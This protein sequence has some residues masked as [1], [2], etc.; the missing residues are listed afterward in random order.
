MSFHERF[1]PHIATPAGYGALIDA[2]QL[3][4]PLPHQLAVISEQHEMDHFGP[5][6]MFTPRHAPDATLE[7]HL[8]FAL[9][10]EGLDLAVLKR[11][12]QAAGPSEI[13]ALVRNTPLG[14]YARRTWFLYE[15]LLGERLDLLDTKQGA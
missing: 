10:Y 12:F 9:K 11:L 3:K 5:W 7:G 13:E 14:I 1:L 4:V 2:Y 8:T 15:W 6:H